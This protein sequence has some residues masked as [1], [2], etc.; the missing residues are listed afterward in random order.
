MRVRN[1]YNAWHYYYTNTVNFPAC[2]LK[3][4]RPGDKTEDDDGEMCI[5]Y[6]SGSYFRDQSNRN[7]KWFPSWVIRCQV[8]KQQETI[9]EVEAWKQQKVEHE[10]RMSMYS[11]VLKERNKH[12]NEKCTSCDVNIDKETW[13]CY[14]GLCAECFLNSDED[15]DNW[16]G[17]PKPTDTNLIK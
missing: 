1:G 13:F 10:K 15:V 6:E 17:E 2:C 4:P 8:C 5:A 9:M 14:C 3:H 11:Q 12:L 7:I 16:L